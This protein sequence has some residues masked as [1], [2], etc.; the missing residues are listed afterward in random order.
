MYCFRRSNTNS[1]PIFVANRNGG[2]STTESEDSNGLRPRHRSPKGHGARPES[3]QT[4]QLPGRGIERHNRVGPSVIARAQSATV[5]IGASATGRNKNQS[6]FDIGRNYRPGISRTRSP[7]RTSYR[8][9]GIPSPAEFTR[10]YVVAPH[11]PKFCRGELV[12]ADIGTNYHDVTYHGGRRCDSIR[13][14]AALPNACGQVNSCVL[15]E[16]RAFRPRLLASTAIRRASR[17]ANKNPVAAT[18]KCV[19]RDRLQIATP[20]RRHGAKIQCSIKLRIEF[21]RSPYQKR[22]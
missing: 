21:P 10:S 22:D 8:R 19:K 20:R 18:A 1:D 14:V 12:I 15:S 17:D 11:D 9:H 2:R 3:P 6:P 13:R 5:E 7:K 16:T 4:S